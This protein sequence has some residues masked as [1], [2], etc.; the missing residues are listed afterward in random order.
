MRDKCPKDV[1]KMKEKERK[2][3]RNDRGGQGRHFPHLVILP[4][5]F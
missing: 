2:I 5:V 4:D 3:V 1:E